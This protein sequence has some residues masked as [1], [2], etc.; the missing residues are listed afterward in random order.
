MSHLKRA[1]TS[2]QHARTRAAIQR[3]CV[4]ALLLFSATPALLV[5]NA[6]QRD[7]GHSDM[8]VVI[9]ASAF[10]LTLLLA[11]IQVLPRTGMIT[12]LIVSLISIPQSWFVFHYGWPLDSNALSLIAETNIA[13]AM[14]FLGSIPV[15]TWLL[16]LT[17]VAL[18]VLSFATRSTECVPERKTSQYRF[19]A[20]SALGLIAIS[21]S[22]SWASAVGI[23][24]VPD[25][26]FPAAPRGQA[27]ALRAAYPASLP[28]LILDYSRD[29]NSLQKAT[30][31][32]LAFQFGASQVVPRQQRR[33]FLV[34]VGE[35]A[36]AD[37]FQLNGYNRE[38]TPRLSRTEDIISFTRMYSRSTFTRLSV[39]VILSRKPPESFAATFHE[40]SI[41][42]AF[43]EAGFLT[44]W[45]SLQAPLGYHE[46]PTSVHAREADHVV[47]L[48]PVDYRSSGKLDDAG[49][50]AL[51]R[52]I[53]ETSGQD[54][55]VVL[56]ALGSHF[57]YSD[58]YPRSFAKF[59]PDHRKNRP[60]RLFAKGDKD[61]L[62]NSYDNS[63]LFTDHV[64][65]T[66]IE[67]LKGLPQ[68]ESWLMYVSDHGEAL[69]DDCRNYSGHG[70]SA[71]ATQS[72]AA[73]F[74][75]SPSFA[76]RHPDL[77]ANMTHNRNELTST[78]M[79]FETLVSLGGLS[80]PN[81]RAQND[82]A[83]RNLRIPIEVANV[84][85]LDA[86]ACQTPN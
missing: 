7:L 19:V 63:I 66:A 12:L 64:L 51:E 26:T 84:E 32:N 78:A 3:G 75:P 30:E 49:L 68:T 40:A 36:R 23:H 83:R 54:L 17:P 18:A 35:T 5:A 24:E 62:V 60:L 31:R 44:S 34:V 6:N 73:L 10:A 20:L 53:E 55:F 74:W 25:A 22:A 82:L 81:P 11:V 45:I 38:T 42:S 28:L 21:V 86:E 8:V 80:V 4:T 69:F 65:A 15:W 58:R 67:L 57:R 41:V 29:R 46:S 16:A 71:K 56:H 48:N 59:L 85:A 14:D 79:M 2:A 1:K 27:L 9:S 39:P 50:V 43:R 52:L 61:Y 13:E 33:V 76:S 37:H 70:H 77:I 47:F 72:V